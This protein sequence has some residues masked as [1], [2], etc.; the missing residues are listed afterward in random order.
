MEDR[1][2]NKR[3]RLDDPGRYTPELISQ[4]ISSELDV[5]FHRQNETDLPNGIGGLV[6]TQICARIIEQVNLDSG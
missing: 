5:H 1:K 3:F 2:I 6:L 4:I